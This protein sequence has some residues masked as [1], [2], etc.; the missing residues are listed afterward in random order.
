MKSK[1]LKPAL[2]IA[3]GITV[4]A[5]KVEVSYAS[6]A[7][8]AS[9]TAE[10]TAKEKYEENYKYA[11]A[12]LVDLKEV[13]NQAIYINEKDDKVKRLYNSYLQTLEST[14]KKYGEAET[15]DFT[16]DQYDQASRDIDSAL[17]ELISYKD[18]LSG[19]KV[20]NTELNELVSKDSDFRSSDAY[21]N[22][23]ESQQK[24]YT[25][26][27]EDAKNAIKQ[28]ENVSI[29]EYET[30]LKNLKNAREAIENIEKYNKAKE[31]LKAE[32]LSANELDKS[33]FTEKSYRVFKKALI[34]AEST[35]NAK[36]STID[37]YQTSLD[38][39][40]TAKEA[41]VKV[42]SQE[43]KDLQESVKNLKKALD[44]NK[45]KI[46]AVNY[47][48]EYTPSTVKGVRDK[49]EKLVKESEEIIEET[50]QFLN[51]I[52]KIKG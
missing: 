38:T 42:D 7:T 33:L 26:A 28:F 52:E 36:N 46:A 35:V 39:L 25:K 8:T 43:E 51:R 37:Q 40:K 27:I 47:L 1:I 41:L 50:Q 3:L 6:E 14:L 15:K 16:S 18:K 44:D 29:S 11:I 48:F 24:A 34:A 4:L 13:K 5:P 22:A 10:K 49:L 23:S 9:V 21:K 12:K 2:L 30:A 17:A 31:E 20:S 32:I 45:T 19:K